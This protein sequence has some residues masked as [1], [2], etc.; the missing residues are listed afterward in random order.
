ME[1]ENISAKSNFESSLQ[2]LN[3][4]GSFSSENQTRN[5]FSYFCSKVGNIKPH[6]S[7]NV[8]ESVL[9]FSCRTGYLR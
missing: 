7:V 4:D 8:V 3:D 1:V 2:T 5:I 6:L 9:L